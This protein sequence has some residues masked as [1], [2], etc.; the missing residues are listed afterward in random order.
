MQNVPN[1]FRDNTK[2]GF[3]LPV[4]DRVRMELYDARGNLR[5]RLTDRHYEP[6]EHVVVL[7]GGGLEAGL[8]LYRMTATGF[9]AVKRLLLVK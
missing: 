4:A 2:I 8:Y 1:P 9:S 6:G 5:V 3:F 7:E